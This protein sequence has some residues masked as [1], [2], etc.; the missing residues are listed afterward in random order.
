MPSLGFAHVYDYSG[1]GESVA[2]PVVL[3]SG[4]R[5]VHLAA[6]VDTGAS[7][8]LFSGEIAEAL[9]LNLENGIRRRFRTANSGFDTFGHEV[10]LSVLGIATTS[11]VYFFADPMIDKNVLGRTGW[12][13]RVRLGLVHHDN[14]V[15]LAPYDPA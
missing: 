6:S 7:F 13:D 5:Q 10:E 11:V 9:G 12:L 15:Y 2:L 4:A 3:R 14:R 1:D 8:C